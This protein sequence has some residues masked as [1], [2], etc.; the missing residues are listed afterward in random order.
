MCIFALLL[1]R[2]YCYVNEVMKNKQERE[3]EGGREGGREGERD[4]GVVVIRIEMRNDVKC[5]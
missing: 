2:T 3:R 4:R 1:P 5:L